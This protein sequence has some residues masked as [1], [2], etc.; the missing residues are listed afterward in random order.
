MEL[1]PE[2]ILP[3]MEIIRGRFFRKTSTV[4]PTTEELAEELFAQELKQESL[5]QDIVN[6]NKSV[7]FIL[8]YIDIIFENQFCRETKVF[9]RSILTIP[10]FYMNFYNLIG[11]CINIIIKSII[12]GL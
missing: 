11:Y 12:K 3:S 2:P 7:I 9:S 1:L 4:E 5:A 10:S 6:N 8:L